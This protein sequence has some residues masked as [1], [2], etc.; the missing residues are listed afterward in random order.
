[1][2]CVGGAPPETEVCDCK[3]NN[4][5]GQV[6]NGGLCGAGATCLGAGYCQCAFPCGGGEFPCAAGYRCA[7]ATA[8]SP[9]FCVPDPCAQV[10]C[11]RLPNGTTQTCVDGACVPLCNIIT[12]NAG[13]V[14]RA[15]DGQCVTNN[16]LGL[17]E[18]CDATQL[19]AGGTCVPN[20]CKDVMCPAGQFCRQGACVGSCS[21][22]ACAGKS[23]CRDGTCQSDACAGVGCPSGAVCDPGTGECVP[24]ACLLVVCG[25]GR[26]C[27]GLSG[28]CETDPCTGITCPAGQF[29]AKGNCFSAPD[30]DG[31]KPRE[32]VGVRGTGL[33]TCAYGASR[34]EPAWLWLVAAFAMAHAVRRKR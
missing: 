8:T 29:C 24:D 4:C 27:N 17:P 30:P 21:R 16:C 20:L 34:Q 3:D 33:L 26:V 31:D 1:V 15:N 12:C 23:S 13:L 10:R 11:P 9:G 2:Q 18:L 25:Q 7:D 32:Y 14:C 6:D 28:Q 5:D 22:I 19:C